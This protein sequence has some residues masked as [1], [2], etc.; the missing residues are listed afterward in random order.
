MPID[1]YITRK[2]GNL[3]YSV[4][5]GSLDDDAFECLASYLK[6][7]IYDDFIIINI[8]D[9]ISAMNNCKKRESKKAMKKILDFYIEFEINRLREEIK[10]NPE[11]KKE[12]KEQIKNIRKN[13]FDHSFYIE[14]NRRR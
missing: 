8:K 3:S 6:R 10:R 1:S 11:K 13:N 9:F 4:R 12:I 7:S 2:F 5:L 14:I